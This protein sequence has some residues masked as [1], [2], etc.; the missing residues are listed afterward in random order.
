MDAAPR[1]GPLA[2]I[3]GS[4][5]LPAEIAAEVRSRGE[6]VV[7]LPLKGIADVDFGDIA[8]ETVGLLDPAGAI[9]ALGRAHASG[10]VLAG[11]VHK[12]SLG[13]VLAGWQ[14]VRRGD[15]IR[16]IV[17]G[18]DDNLL[19]GVVAYLEGSGFPVLGVHQV[20]PRLMAGEEQLGHTV[21]TPA[22]EADIACGLAALA[23][24]GPLD[25]GQAVVVAERRVL[26]V[27]AVEGTDQ[28][29]RRV[30][31]LRRGGLT[32]RLARHG[33]PPVAERLRG[34]L[35]KAPKATQDFRVDLPV[36]GPRTLRL[37]AAAGLAGLAVA[38]G[39][40]L[41]IDRAALAAEADLRGLFVVGRAR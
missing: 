2:I 36:V 15:E 25:I 19:R 7:V 14:A 11:T 3:A 34:V 8:G 5:R 18:G 20:A 6:A 13:L 10:V 16:R 21:P 22:D 28:M 30:A 1:P 33:R 38:A 32:G 27:E 40:V 4:G 29:L 12:P 41:L 24:M 37:A 26:A 31:G 39:G 17:Q 9:A 23:A 35:I